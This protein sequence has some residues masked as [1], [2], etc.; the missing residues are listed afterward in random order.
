[1]RRAA[2]SPAA[3]WG[4]LAACLLPAALALP[5]CAKRV[6]PPVPQGEDYLFAAAAPGEVSAD[7][8]AALRAAWSEVIA[9]DTPS[10]ARRYE[11]LLKRRPG[12][13]AARTGLAFAR[14]R[15][16]RLEE[17]SSGFDAVL[18]DHPDELPALVGAVSVAVRRGDADAALGFYRR[19]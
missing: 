9:G 6:V 18:T 5:G 2:R 11:K 12:L 15:A 17:A 1:V 7:E 10:A 4:L 14:L 16:G 8:A 13:A 3:A 19:A